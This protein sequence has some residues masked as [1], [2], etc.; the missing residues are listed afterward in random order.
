MAD[1]NPALIPS[2]T[3]AK[4]D[5]HFRAGLVKKRAEDVQDPQA[6][7]LSIARRRYR[8]GFTDL[9]G[10]TAELKALEAPADQIP[11][12]IIAGD[13]EAGY[14]YAMDLIN[15][16]RDAFRAGN[17]DIPTYAERIRS[18]VI[19]RDRA[20]TYVARELARI[21]PDKEPTLEP[22]PQAT[23][24]TDAG[25]VEV[26]TIRRRRRKKIITREDELVKLQALGMPLDL[27]M[28]YADNDDARLAGKAEEE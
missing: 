2:A 13:L 26:D 18:V 20:E 23:Y 21:R 24:E 22:A 1:K 5:R 3:L 11:L 14:D 17:I 16:Y 28:S 12:E 4:I 27:A 19:R 7:R 10:F 25:K 6:F 9:E 15:V 8:E